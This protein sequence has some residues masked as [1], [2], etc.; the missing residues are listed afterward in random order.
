MCKELLI[1]R[2]LFNYYLI[3]YF[4]GII[5]ALF[6]V[7]IFVI[8]YIAITME[9]VLRTDKLIP[10]L[11]MMTFAWIGVS[12]GMGDFIE[13]FDGEKIMDI[14]AYTE[15]ERTSLLESSLLHHL[16]K[17][18]EILIFL[19]G[20]M[21]IVE[22]IDHFNGFSVIK[23][24][25]KTNKKL[26]L[27]WIIGGLAFVLSAIIDN[28]TSTIVLITIMRKL[29]K[30]REDR[31]WFA[32]LIVIAANSGGAWSP[33]GDVTTTM[34]WMGD[35]VSAIKLM[36]YVLLPALVSFVVPFTFV[37][38]MKR[39]KGRFDI[40][41]NEEAANGNGS[42][43]LYVGLIMIVFVPVLKGV[44]GLPPY[45]GMM[46]SLAIVSIFGEVV[47]TREFKMSFAGVTKESKEYQEKKNGKGPTLL[48][49]TKIEMPSILFFL[50]ILMTVAAME[51]LG[52]I[53]NFGTSV[54]EAMHIDLFIIIL[55]L[56]SAVI[57]NVPLV[58]ASMGMFDL[59]MDHMV[60]HFIAYSAGTGG[61]VLI[62]GSAAGVVA[63]GMERISFFWYVKKISGLALLGFFAGAGVYLL[64]RILTGTATM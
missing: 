24:F 1:L 18:A 16:G 28:L 4:S 61:S 50:G 56:A 30:D 19:I 44:F 23:G 29:I 46:F 42:L 45:L 55:G 14:S 37:S 26:S 3:N 11:L 32:G 9:H 41:E 52:L 8:G 60:W 51:S 27:L 6:V 13:W 57:D 7:F 31:L 17:T 10:A 21:T 35:K 40:P 53:F 49:L 59:P 33:I 25:V 63:M 36:E 47:S 58:A 12:L 15:A 38:F 54:Q 64:E 20:A 48:A 43:M 34:L 39:F 2:S 22:I 5:M 62:I